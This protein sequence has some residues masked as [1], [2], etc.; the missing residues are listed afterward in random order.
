MRSKVLS[1]CLAALL[2]AALIPAAA[3]ADVGDY[4]VYTENGK[5]LYVRET[6]GGRIVGNLRYGAKVHVYSFADANWALITF[7]YTK[8]GV[9]GEYNAY[10]N[11][12]F[13]T[14][15]KPAARKSAEAPADLVTE[16]NQ[17]FKTAQK[18]EPYEVVIRPTRVTGW[19][20]M[21]WAPSDSAELLA[22]YK[23]N[24][25]LTV[26]K[27]LDGWLQVEDPATGNIGFI[28]RAFI[29]E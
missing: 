4:Y 9:A 14:K 23:A 20:P 5:S 24:D 2:L 10:V 21:Y 7:R 1:L 13:L 3:L 19:V 12:R 25:V 22:T 28:K 29:A 17:I 6:P 8:N 11:R 26:R 27:E 18:V 16:I 15:S